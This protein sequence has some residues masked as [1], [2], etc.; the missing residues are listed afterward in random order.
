MLHWM[1]PSSIYFV[2]FVVTHSLLLGFPLMGITKL[3]GNLTLH[4]ALIDQESQ[5]A[6]RVGLAK[7][8]SVGL[9]VI[10]TWHETCVKIAAYDESV[11]EI[12]VVAYDISLAANDASEAQKECEVPK[13]NRFDSLSQNLDSGN[14]DPFSDP[15][16]DN[17]VPNNPKI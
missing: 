10:A 9:R 11:P 7:T 2:M 15:S 5:R 14:D 6:R 1:L 16:S 4:H 3:S 17:R 12:T 13:V 8:R